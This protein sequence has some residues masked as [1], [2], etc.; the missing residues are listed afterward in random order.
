MSFSSLRSRIG[1]PQVIALGLLLV[2]A[3]QCLWFMAHMPL[4]AREA[5]HV[6]AGLLQLERLASAGTRVHSPL[7]PLLGGIAARISGAERHIAELNNYRM[8]L[9][10]PFLVAGFLLGASVW[11]VARRLYGNTGGY[12][13]VALYCFSPVIVGWA[14]QVGPEIIG[15]WGAFG[16]VFTA[17]AVSHTLYAPREVVLWNWRRIL[18]LGLSIAMCVGAR[19]SLWI[20][21]LP[22]LAFMLWVGHR[23]R[24]AAL[25]IFSAAC[26]VGALLLWALYTFRPTAFSRALSSADWLGSSEAGVSWSAAGSTFGPFFLENGIGLLLL[27]A[28]T[29]ATFAA[30]KRTRFFGTATP[31][32]VAVLLLAC[33]LRMN[34][35][36]FPYLFTALP[37]LILF[38]AG[39]SA[40]LLESRYALAA[41]AVVGGVL[42]ANAMID[43]YG[44]VHLTSRSG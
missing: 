2:F 44:L 13:A 42:V 23:R 20:V 19:F 37:F 1:V 15:A 10:A 40:D 3:G 29:L 14:S 12:V 35:D 18:L 38:M 27:L 32:I 16:L 36:A 21:L 7:A 4:T 31:L 22:A 33:G 24:S 17:I 8:V 43:I 30:W 39:V 28:V 41:N 34:F 9:R 26:A 25:V 11:Y 6:E 5:F